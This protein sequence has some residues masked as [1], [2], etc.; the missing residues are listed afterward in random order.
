[1]HVVVAH[2]G[3][4]R[5]SYSYLTAASVRRGD[6]VR[7]GDVLGTSGGTGVNHD[8]QVLHFGLRSGDEYL[9]PMLLFGAVDLARVVHLAPTAAPFGYTVAQERRGLLAGLRDFGAGVVDAAAGAGGAVADLAPDVDAI[10]AA[11]DPGRRPR[12][13]DGRPLRGADPAS[14]RRLPADRRRTRPRSARA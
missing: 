5:T 8:G 13:R 9:D 2:A 6:A 7:A 11:L 3:G 12:A 14:A 10:T 4:L 1:M